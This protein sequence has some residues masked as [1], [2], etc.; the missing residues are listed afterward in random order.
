MERSIGCGMSG[1][2]V[3]GKGGRE[4]KQRGHKRSITMKNGVISR[5]LLAP[6]ALSSLFGNGTFPFL[7][8][9]QG[10]LWNNWT[11]AEWGGNIA[12]HLAM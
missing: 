8:L 10:I 3:R 11:Q 5:C 4:E 1:S 9:Q 2:R 7:S 12:L 6:P